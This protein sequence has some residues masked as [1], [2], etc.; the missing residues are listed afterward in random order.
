MPHPL[1][2]S[3]PQYPPSKEFAK[4]PQGPPLDFQLLC[5]YVCMQRN[6]SLMFLRDIFLHFIE[7]K[8]SVSK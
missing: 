5:I 8:H 7:V 1:I 4:K 6:F 3:Q 2:F